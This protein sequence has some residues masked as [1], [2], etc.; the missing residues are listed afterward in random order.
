MAS[1]NCDHVIGN[2]DVIIDFSTPAALS[3]LLENGHDAMRGKALVVGTTG[4][5]SEID[6]KLDELAR[7][8]AVLTAAN[9]SIG[10]NL[11]I[12]LV[13]RAAAVL[14]ARFDIEIVEAHHR[15]KIDA[16]S[17]TALALGRA[18]AEG[19]HVNLDDVRTDG[20]SGD[21]GK[22]TEGG[23]AFHAL[24]GGSVVGEHHVHF[25]GDVERVEL[26]HIATDR[27]LFANGALAAAQW[28]SARPPGRYTMRDVL[29]LQE[30]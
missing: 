23:I 19:R 25:L 7:S 6:S 28:L 1:D 22:R 9:F 12:D 16:P 5:T 14:D 27:V 13:R 11:L 8:T 17:G 3:T 30:Q 18:A 24:R 21:T 10:V 26:S 29:G 20:R 2:A 15:N 4:L